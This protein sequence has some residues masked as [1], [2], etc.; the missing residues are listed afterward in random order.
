MLAAV[1]EVL[2]FWFLVAMI[3][4][5]RS[6]LRTCLGTIVMFR[7]SWFLVTVIAELCS[8]LTSLYTSRHFNEWNEDVGNANQTYACEGG[9]KL[10]GPI[11]DTCGSNNQIQGRNRDKSNEARSINLI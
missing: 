7:K 11:V 4:Q 10:D 8:R 1:F 5:C 9:S 6:F 3:A 2:V